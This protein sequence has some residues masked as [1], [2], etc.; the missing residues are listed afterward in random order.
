MGKEK[1][2]GIRFGWVGLVGFS[3]GD[4]LELGFGE[5]VRVKLKDERKG[6]RGRDISLSKGVSIEVGIVET[7]L[8]IY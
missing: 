6:I 7:C 5:R 3:R 8:G 4:F 2:C 1:Y